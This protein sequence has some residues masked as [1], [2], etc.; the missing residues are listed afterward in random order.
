MSA[1]REKRK[2]QELNE[3]GSQKNGRV[4]IGAIVFRNFVT[5]LCVLLVLALIGMVLIGQGLPQQYMTAVTADGQKISV[6]E[7]NFFYYG[8]VSDFYNNMGE[9]LA[10]YGYLDSSKSLDSQESWTEGETWHDYVVSS[11]IETIKNAVQWSEL[12]KAEGVTM[13]E[14]DIATIDTLIA[15]ATESA[16]VQGMSLNKLLSTVYGRGVNEKNI[17]Q[18]IERQV[19]ASRYE[20]QLRES[21]TFTEQE[22]DTY[23]NENK[24]LFDTVD[25]RA[26]RVSEYLSDAEYAKLLE[27]RGVDEIDLS[28][29]V[30]SPLGEIT[31]EAKMAFDKVTAFA[32]N[33]DLTEENFNELAGEN[34]YDDEKESYED[35]DFTLTE[36]G[37]YSEDE[38]NDWLFDETRKYGEV[39][40]LKSGEEYIA[41]MFLKRTVTDDITVTLRQLVIE[42]TSDN[43]TGWSEAESIANQ[44][45][46][47]LGSSEQNFIKSGEVT[48]SALG[49]AYESQP[50][51]EMRNSDVDDSEAEIKEWLFNPERKQGDTAVIKSSSAYH[52]MYFSSWGRPYWQVNV[53]NTLR[54]EKNTAAREEKSA[55]TP[56]PNTNWFG[57]QLISKA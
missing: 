32:N 38:L 46:G 42:P 13:T 35:A 10:S 17:R 19:L 12:A 28:E 34:A 7:F 57:M 6:A 45:L 26:F 54:D 21:F 30:D 16:E 1:S 51:T 14:E 48:K 11:T 56:E 20:T 52:V 44:I 55:N 18:F 27:E 25:Y 43:E 50:I 5:V 8:S 36:N 24:K 41:V 22:I 47:A 4:D 49:T 33:P 29:T 37:T 53:E 15:S 9:F 31:I 2:R 40:V 3:G 23:Y 39:T